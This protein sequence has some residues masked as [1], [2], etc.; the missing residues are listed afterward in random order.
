MKQR[1]AKGHDVYNENPGLTAEV[2]SVQGT[3]SSNKGAE[4]ILFEQRRREGAQLLNDPKSPP[5]S[6]KRS[7]V[8]EVRQK[9][10]DY[11]EDLKN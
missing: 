7:K 11:S 10:S 4:G 9:V 2:H 8:A 5:L 6:D 3:A 1:L